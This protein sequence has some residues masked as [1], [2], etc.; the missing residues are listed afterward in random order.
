MENSLILELKGLFNQYQ[1]SPSAKL[2]EELLHSE[3]KFRSSH[4]YWYLKALTAK[5]I[6][7]EKIAEISFYKALDLDPKNVNL[8]RDISIFHREN[9]EYEKALQHA[10]K[11]VQYLPNN[12]E[13]QCILAS[14]YIKMHKLSEADFAIS[15][16]IEIDPENAT[17]LNTLGK[18]QIAK[19]E[20]DLAITTF[21]KSLMTSGSNF[22][23]LSN[24]AIA[25]YSANQLSAALGCYEMISDDMLDEIQPK[26]LSQFIFNRSLA[27]LASG[28]CEKGWRD[29]FFRFKAPAF[30]SLYRKFNVPRL[31]RI[32]DGVG[33]TLLIWPEQGIGDHFT[34]LSLIEVLKKC[35]DSN[36]VILCDERMRSLLAR[37]FPSIKFLEDKQSEIKNVTFD[38][39]LPMGDIASLLKF[40]KSKSLIIKPYIKADPKLCDF[41]K[42]QLSEDK[43]K[44]GLAWESGVKNI[45]RNLHYTNIDQWRSLI[46][47]PRVQVVNLQYGI[48]ENALTGLDSELFKRIYDP[49]FDLKN[50]F[51]NLS[52]LI[53]NLDLVISPT[54]AIMAHSASVGIPTISY[55]A[56]V[57]D[58]ALGSINSNNTFSIPWLC[59]NTVHLFDMKNKEKVVEKIIKFVE[60]TE[61]AFKSAF[62]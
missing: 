57:S 10:L 56:F 55:S 11:F 58:K 26:A 47:N 20:F 5:K 24:L 43:Y 27:L 39:H 6:G 41:W 13:S 46:E 18:L 29:Y 32:S 19:G 9:G 49:E 15:K 61:M 2:L 22:E 59:E 21:K 36:L 53:K 12:S 28:N 44:V 51:E 30:T 23:T 50:D 42:S 54:S 34:F 52:A 1:R 7:R 62:R 3:N 17:T 40:D 16:A 38:F 8:L 48:T 4:V 31:T 14:T 25:Y 37:S 45:R 60:N 33:K 35:T